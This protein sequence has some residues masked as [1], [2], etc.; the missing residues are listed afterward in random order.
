VSLARCPC[1][2]HSGVGTRAYMAPEQ[3]NGGLLTTAADVW[4]L[5]AV[6]YEAASGQTPFETYR[7]RRYDQLERRAAPLRCH[8][9]LP[10][11]FVALVD[12]C[13]DPDPLRRPTI[14]ELTEGLSALT[15]GH[16]HQTPSASL[17]S[18]TS[19]SSAPISSTSST[20]STSSSSTSSSSTSS[21]S[22]SRSSA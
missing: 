19:S 3:A 11:A 9:R 20:S 7:G 21:S 17:S 12:S 2:G 10:A 14:A 8:R 1:R 13:L 15:S 4:G 22:A 5:G 6:L 18:S 16:A